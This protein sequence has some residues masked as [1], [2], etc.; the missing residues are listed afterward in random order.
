MDVATANSGKAAIDV[1]DQVTM[2][3]CRA[4]I[5][6]GSSAP[7]TIAASLYRFKF[8]VKAKQ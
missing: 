3:C 8:V 2:W 1:M 4:D 7:E 5:Y 6:G